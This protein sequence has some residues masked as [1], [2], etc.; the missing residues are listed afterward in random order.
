MLP[1]ALT[2]AWQCIPWLMLQKHVFMHV[3]NEFRTKRSTQRYRNQ[4]QVCCLG[5]GGGGGGC[6]V[7]AVREG[8]LQRDEAGPAK[9]MHQKNAH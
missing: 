2:P 3:A 9:A 4:V 8:S 5:D 1:N 7:M 6:A